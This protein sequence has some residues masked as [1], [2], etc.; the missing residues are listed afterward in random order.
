[1]GGCSVPPPPAVVRVFS[2][3]LASAASAS[4]A[5]SA[6]TPGSGFVTMTGLV[7]NARIGVPVTAPAPVGTCQYFLSTASGTLNGFGVLKFTNVPITSATG[8]CAQS[9][10]ATLTATFS[11]VSSATGFGPVSVY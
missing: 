7:L 10:P 6:F 11:P 3:S 1:M 4:V 5:A 9:L 2:V 8:V